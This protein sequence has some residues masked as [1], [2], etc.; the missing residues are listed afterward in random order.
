MPRLVRSSIGRWL[1]PAIVYTTLFGDETDVVWLDSGPAATAGKSYLGRAS[2]VV[3]SEIRDRK[4][5]V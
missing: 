1:D 5:V 2:R 4:S 3:T